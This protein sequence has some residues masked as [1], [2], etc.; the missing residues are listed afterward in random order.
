L[1]DAKHG[2]MAALLLTTAGGTASGRIGAG[3]GGNGW[4]FCLIGG[5]LGSLIYVLI[6]RLSGDSTIYDGIENSLGKSTGRLVI[7][8][9]SLF[10]LRLCAHEIALT[11]VFISMTLL[12]K[13]PIWAVCLPLG[14][15]CVLSAF[16]GE[17]AILQWA[18]MMMPPVLLLLI[19]AILLA[20]PEVKQIRTDPIELPDAW[21]SV[22][23]YFLLAFSGGYGATVMLG[24]A[25]EKTSASLWA[26][27]ISV[28]LG[29]IT[30]LW[31]TALLGNHMPEKFCFPTYHAMRVIGLSSFE[32]RLEAMLMLPIV[33]MSFL[34]AA[35]LFLFGVR[36]M[37][38]SL[39][40]PRSKTVPIVL[41]AG[42][43]A[44]VSF[45]YPNQS[46][47]DKTERSMRTGILF[48]VLLPVL[49]SV[50]VKRI[51]SRYAQ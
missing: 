19:L 32:L 39:R 27:G 3:A 34:R 42:V 45:L 46:V 20:S 4:L 29:M 1:K 15:L 18:K 37:E 44:M 10:T 8:L 50:F 28:L 7:L 51:K 22:L 24:K 23:D 16:A 35:T 43:V 6:C 40:M 38:E 2:Y 26:L 5:F 9:L 47:L 31:N 49:L 41:M 25:T 13:T 14:L 17:R 30:S 21:N 36:G 48:L 33:L 11:S 12:D